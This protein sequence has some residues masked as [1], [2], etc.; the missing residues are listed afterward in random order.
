MAIASPEFVK[1]ILIRGAIPEASATAVKFTR[2]GIFRYH[3]F[4]G[5]QLAP[6]LDSSIGDG[7]VK[8]H[9]RAFELSKDD[10]LDT[11]FVNRLHQHIDTVG[12]FMDGKAII[13]YIVGERAA[14][15][16]PSMEESTR[17]PDFF[18]KFFKPEQ[19][20]DQRV[21]WVRRATEKP[22]QGLR[23]AKFTPESLLEY[24]AGLIDEIGGASQ[25]LAAAKAARGVLGDWTE[26]NLYPFD[27]D[28]GDADQ[29]VLWGIYWWQGITPKS[30]Q[31]IVDMSRGKI[32]GLYPGQLKGHEGVNNSQSTEIEPLAKI[33][34]KLNIN[35][36]EGDAVLWKAKANKKI[37]PTHKALHIKHLAE[38]TPNRIIRSFVPSPNLS[39]TRDRA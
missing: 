12:V 29:P 11:R 25:N 37:V 24:Y 15:R 30:P 4:A 21:L 5:D 26:N 8:L 14:I 22:Y 28:Y 34:K 1:P 3:L 20:K 19:E 17:F 36:E 33:F 7:V 16:V 31:D 6:A 39:L 32:P 27:A 35:E 38:E 13:S 2:E 23:L 10:E 9:R 18:T